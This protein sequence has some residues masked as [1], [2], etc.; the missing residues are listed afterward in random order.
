MTLPPQNRERF[1][2]LRA[3]SPIDAVRAWLAGDFGIGDE[4]AMIE[5]I[6]R[7]TQVTL[8]NDAIIDAFFDAIDDGLDA[9]ACLGRLTGSR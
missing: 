9:P 3:L 1:E 2:R 8:S 4:P 6:R 7:D 5:A